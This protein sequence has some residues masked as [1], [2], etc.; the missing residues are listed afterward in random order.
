ML[1]CE[2]GAADEGLSEFVSE[3]RSSVR[4]LNQYLFGRLIKPPDEVAWILLPI[5]VLP[6]YGDRP[7]YK[8]AVPAIGRLATSATESV[9]VF[10]LPYRW[11]LR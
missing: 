10:L 2:Q 7:S 3:I 8:L 1:E 5:P 4:G 11:Q 6:L 9:R